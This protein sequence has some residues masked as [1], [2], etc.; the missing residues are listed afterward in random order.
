MAPF[1]T[2]DRVIA[3]GLAGAALTGTISGLLLRSAGRLHGSEW[4][5]L[6]AVQHPDNLQLGLGFGSF[7]LGLATVSLG[8]LALRNR[9]STM[10]LT[11]G[12]ILLAM[13][14]V[15]GFALIGF[16]VGLL[17]TGRGINSFAIDNV[18][19]LKWEGKNLLAWG[20]FVLGGAAA[21]I[22][23]GIGFGEA[24]PRLRRAGGAMAFAGLL[25]PPL[26]VIGGPL[27]A[28]SFLWLAFE[29]FLSPQQAPAESSVPVA[30][31]PL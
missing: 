24:R 2:A 13:A 7:A 21:L 10:F 22:S 31:A 18:F 3:A 17:R 19:V 8:A 16:D 27:L 5:A 15:A 20:V 28:F 14:A 11:V 4:S 12:A 23:L 26:P 29:I 6:P 9:R 30:P 1:S 25:I